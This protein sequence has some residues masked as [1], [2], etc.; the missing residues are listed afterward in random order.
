M[1]GRDWNFDDLLEQIQQVKRMGSLA[2]VLGRIPGLSEVLSEEDIAE[3]LESAETI[4]GAMAPEERRRPELLV[5]QPGADRRQRVAFQSGVSVDDVETLVTQFLA[6]RSRLRDLAEGRP[7][8]PSWIDSLM[9][10]DDGL[11]RGDDEES[12]E[13]DEEE[14]PVAEE[15]EDEASDDDDEEEEEDLDE[16]VDEVLRKLA[17][18]GKGMA[19]LTKDERALLEQASKVYKQ[20]RDED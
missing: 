7:L 1:S 20:R 2:E 15:P 9:P 3:T 8:P 4:L 13:R 10:R 6:A 14:Q 11:P 12:E 19:G 17:R 5:G 16:Q 18:V